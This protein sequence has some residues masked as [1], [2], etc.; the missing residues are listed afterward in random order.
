MLDIFRP[1]GENK[2]DII[3]EMAKNENAYL[4]LPNVKETIMSSG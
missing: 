1:K 2:Y 4:R 3:Y